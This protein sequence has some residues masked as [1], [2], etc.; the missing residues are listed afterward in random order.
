MSDIHLEG[1]KEKDWE[2]WLDENEYRYLGG[3]MYEC[4][5]NHVWH[6]GDLIKLFEEF[7]NGKQ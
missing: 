2:D 1:Q 7:Q 3:E 4:A 6:V 5:G